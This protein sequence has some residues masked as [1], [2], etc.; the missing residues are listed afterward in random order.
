MQ[1][2]GKYNCFF[3]QYSNGVSGGAGGGGILDVFGAG[4]RLGGDLLLGAL[5]ELTPVRLTDDEAN[6]PT[7]RC[8]PQRLNVRPGHLAGGREEG[9]IRRITQ[10]THRPRVSKTASMQRILSSQ[11]P[12]GTNAS[13]I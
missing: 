11:H 3:I 1:L 2:K 10:P 6:L 13:I 8:L 5:G 9:Q 12:G 4:E 7:S